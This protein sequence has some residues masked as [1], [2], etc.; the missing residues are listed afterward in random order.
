MTQSSTA[1]DSQS[2]LDLAESARSGGE[3]E[4]GISYAQQAADIA[5]RQGDNYAQASALLLLGN[6]LVKVGEYERAARSCDLAITLLEA[7]GDEAGVCEALTFQAQAYSYLGLQEEALSVLGAGLEVA[8]RLGDKALLF[9]TSNRIGALHCDM[10]DWEQAEP[11]L[12]HAYDLSV[13]HNL[14]TEATFCILNN[15]ASQVGG[16]VKELRAQGEPERAEEKL[17]EGLSYARAAVDIARSVSHP[18]R[19]AI[20]LG[21]LAML[22]GLAGEFDDAAAENERSLELS[23]MN[24]YRPL[25]LEGLKDN[26][27]LLLLRG[28]VAGAIERFTQVLDLA[29]DINEPY[30]VLDV[31][32][33]LSAA[34]ELIGDFRTA[35]KHYR[36]YHRIERVVHTEVANR[37]AKMLTHRFELHNARLEA[38]KARL[39]A[40]L[41]MLRSHDLEAEKKA[42]QMRASELGRFANTDPMTGL[43]NRRHMDEQFPGMFK[44]AQ[45][46]GR[47]MCVAIGDI[48][49]FKSVNDRFGHAVGDR[50]L[51]HL[52][53]LLR[54][55]CRPGDTVARM[56]GEE[57]FFAFVD[58]EFPEARATC[59][60]LRKAVEHYAWESIHPGLHVT[61]C[62]GLGQSDG[63]SDAHELLVR[64]DDALYAAKRGGRNRVEPAYTEPE[65]T[66]SPVR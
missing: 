4:L 34:Y 35:L 3:Y 5:V 40:R 21:N 36:S 44:R 50:V 8:Q 28:D 27:E 16:A 26:A 32:Q 20:S 11:F 9:W 23:G 43:W 41:A 56:G 55:G 31:H 15:L 64:A 14:G 38:D 42:L 18:Y 58:T 29:A 25:E 1:I 49:G 39:A 17:R 53:A 7:I 65:S 63:A 46:E 13:K 61:I 12:R 60:R 37:R 19:E 30:V 52:A 45:E 59:E 33:Q 57:F 6:Q 47:S 54:R 10:S 22:L 24:S 2:L 62:F 66:E 51:Q 48:D